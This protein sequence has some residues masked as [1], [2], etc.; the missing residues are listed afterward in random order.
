MNRK[1]ILLVALVINLLFLGVYLSIYPLSAAEDTQ[2]Q[3]AAVQETPKDPGAQWEAL[4]QRE[5]ALSIRQQELEKLEKQIDEKIRKLRE[6]DAGIKA[7]VA[8]YRQ[9]SDERIK[10]LVKIYSSMKP[11]AAASLM[12]SLDTDVAVEVFLNM[13]GEIA[14]GIL[15]YMDTAKAATITQRLM[16]YRNTRQAASAH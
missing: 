6:L 10:H 11:K 1:K 3:P 13:K 14:G 8:A 16:S 7:E 9:I 5:E 12:D 2:P 4:R 15:S